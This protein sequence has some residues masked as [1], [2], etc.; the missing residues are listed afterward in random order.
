MCKEDVSVKGE[1]PGTFV[2][3]SRGVDVKKIN[4]LS[5]LYAVWWLFDVNMSAMGRLRDKATAASRL[6]E[7][8]G[9]SEDLLQM[10]Y[11]EKLY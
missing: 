9:L 2:M 5:S 3:P 6:K 4:T 7:G 10:G 8:R 11:C 1:A